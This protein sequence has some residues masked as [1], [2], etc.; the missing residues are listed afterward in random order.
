MAPSVR[1]PAGVLATA[2]A[3]NPIPPPACSNSTAFID[4]E[5]KSSP[6]QARLR[7]GHQVGAKRSSSL[8]F[9][10]GRTNAFD[11]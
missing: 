5:P 11:F 3:R 4:A 6:I 10:I 1:A 8:I 9:G 2:A 7:I